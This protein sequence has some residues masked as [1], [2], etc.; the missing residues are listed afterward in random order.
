L[1]VLDK[2]VNILVSLI[3]GLEMVPIYDTSL[4]AHR[5]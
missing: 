4:A 2:T 3:G 5:F 1:R